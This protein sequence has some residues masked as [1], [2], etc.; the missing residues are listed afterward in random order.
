MEKRFFKLQRFIDV[1]P[2][3]NGYLGT[4]L[5]ETDVIE[6]ESAIKILEEYALNKGFA[7]KD[8]NGKVIFNHE[9][10]YEG[11]AGHEDDAVLFLKYCNIYKSSGSVKA[12]VIDKPIKE[13]RDFINKSIKSDLNVVKIYLLS[14]K[15]SQ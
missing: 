3:G 15:F 5:A 4:E 2:I 12:T 1:G 14:N 8:S 13:I 10:E 11:I 9:G 6:G 7:K